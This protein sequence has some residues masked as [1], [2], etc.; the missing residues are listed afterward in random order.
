MRSYFIKTAA[1]MKGPFTL[2]VILRGLETG[3]I[4]PNATLVDN[5]TGKSVSAAELTNSAEE[6]Q[7]NVEPPLQFAQPAP[8]TPFAPENAIPN[9]TV[10][11]EDLPTTRPNGL[12][13]RV[14]SVATTTFV[15]ALVAVVIAICLGAFYGVY[16]IISRAPDNGSEVTQRSNMEPM[17]TADKTANQAPTDRNACG[18]PKAN[19]DHAPEP[20]EVK[21]PVPLTVAGYRALFKGDETKAKQA[22]IGK[23][24]LL[25]GYIYPIEKFTGDGSLVWQSDEPLR[26]NKDVL[27]A[28]IEAFDERYAFNMILSEELAKKTV[29]CYLDLRSG[30]WAMIDPKRKVLLAGRAVQTDTFDQC[31]WEFHDD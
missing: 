31:R 14:K 25:V 11:P 7:P 21:K 4:P 22:I 10:N 18:D 17:T 20:K 1:G 13:Q 23:K 27:K 24:A 2:R 9:H 30:D 6:G 16:W 28:Y 26:I 3:K 8:T 19:S 29:R 12:I 5:E 15:L